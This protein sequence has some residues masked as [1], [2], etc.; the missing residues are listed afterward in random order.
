MRASRS[1]PSTGAALVVAALTSCA[2]PPHRQNDGIAGDAPALAWTGDFDWNE[3]LGPSATPS[4]T[5]ATQAP[6]SDLS[7]G[8][9]AS[10]SYFIPVVEILSFQFLLNQYDRHFIDDDVY[11][12]DFSSFEDNLHKGW[13]VDHDPFDTN[14]I[15]HP[16]AGSIY[17]GFARSAGL[18]FWESF[19]Y[20]FVASAL[21]ETAGETGR[22]SINDQVCTGI[23]GSFIGEALFRIASWVLEGDDGSPDFWQ[24]AGA[25][26]ASPTTTFNRHVFGDRFKAIFPSGNP[27]VF[28]R[29]SIG[30]GYY[31]KIS[32]RT[33]SDN[34]TRGVAVAELEMEYGLPGQ[35]GYRY[36]RPFDWF[37]VETRFTSSSN[38]YVES[39]A[40]RGLL[41]GGEYG[42]GDYRGIAGLYGSY[43]YLSPELFHLASTA[44]S[45]GTVGQYWIS[46]SIALRGSALAGVGY[47]AAGTIADNPV[48]RDYHYG[49]VPQC[50]LGVSAALGDRVLLSA[51][52]RD[53][54]VSGAGSASDNGNSENIVRAEAGVTFR[55]W[56]RNAIGLEYITSRRDAPDNATADRHQ[57]VQSAQLVYTYLIG[58]AGKSMGAVDWRGGR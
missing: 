8:A 21:W 53:F 40:F 58:N 50:L 52:V 47:G 33:L 36:D 29:A 37:E 46:K 11:G 7:W 9:E 20:T 17:F 23:G 3:T 5:P 44:L 35:S 56:D 38:A 4:P 10:K 32:D 39:A 51:R 28:S 54:Y 42:S 6:A 34:S 48:D 12:T 14:Q 27:A 25:T 45:L 55:M 49:A 57:T 19:S 24:E 43:D 26:L 2:T 13:I 18:G 31:T 22:P 30:G 41:F 1:R 15:L 16:Y